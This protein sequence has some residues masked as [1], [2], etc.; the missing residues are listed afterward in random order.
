MVELAGKSLSSL[1]ELAK[2]VGVPYPTITGRWK[3]GDR[4]ERLSRPS[5]PKYSR[6]GR[7]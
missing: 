5:D 3:R 6:T 4:G 1:R 2:A 7:W